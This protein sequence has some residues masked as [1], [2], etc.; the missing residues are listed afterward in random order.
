MFPGQCIVYRIGSIPDPWIPA[1]FLSGPQSERPDASGMDVSAVAP[2]SWT[3][4]L[5]DVSCN[6]HPLF[7]HKLD[8]GPIQLATIAHAFN[9]QV[10]VLRDGVKSATLVGR[11]RKAEG[12]ILNDTPRYTLITHL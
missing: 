10:A 12:R 3:I 2:I 4:L 7:T 11:S 1:G 8:A 9:Y 6:L 5:V